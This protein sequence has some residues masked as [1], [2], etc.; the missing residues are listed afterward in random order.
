MADCA[1]KQKKSN[2][3]SKPQDDM[4]AR[5]FRPHTL[6]D[7][8]DKPV[9]LKDADRQNYRGVY[10]QRGH[11]PAYCDDCNSTGGRRGG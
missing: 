3:A 8:P 2:S 4:C 11:A 1:R 6:L 5:K 10:R 7:C 9:M